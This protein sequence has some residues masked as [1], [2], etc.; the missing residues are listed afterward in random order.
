MLL[1]DL[2]SLLVGTRV[3]G[4]IDVPATLPGMVA[5]R[6]DGSHFIRWDDG[7]SSIR[8]RAGRRIHSG[9]YGTAASPQPASRTQ[10]KQHD[11]GA[12]A[13]VPDYTSRV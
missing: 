9:S 12:E 6:G 8:Q 11:E 3:Y 4:E 1:D 5:S 7:Y 10:N 2:L 13:S